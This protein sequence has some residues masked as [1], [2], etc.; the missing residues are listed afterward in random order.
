MKIGYILLQFPV[1]SETFIINELAELTNEGHE[2][3]V[4]SLLHPKKQFV[5]TEVTEYGLLERTYYLPGYIGLSLNLLR[6]QAWPLLFSDAIEVKPAKSKLLGSLFSAAAIDHLS[7]VIPHFNLDVL[8]TH[9]YGLT[10]FVAMQVSQRIGIPFTSTFHAFDIFTKPNAE[11]MRRHMEAAA[12]VITISGYNKDYL[13]KLTGIGA[14][15]TQ[16]IR[17][18]PILD[19]FKN[20]QTE[21]ES[22]SGLIILTVARLVEKKGVKYGILAMA[23][24][25]KEYPHL[26]Y[27]IIGDGPQRDELLALVKS[28]QLENN[29]KFLGQATDMT[30]LA[31]LRS[32][33]MVLLPC[34]QTENGDQDGIPVTLMEAM[35][36]KTP[37][38]STNVSGIPELIEDGKQGLLVEPENTL[39]LANAIKA[40]LNDAELRTR[41]GKAGSNKI[42]KEFNIRIE[43]HKLIE[44]WTA[45]VNSSNFTDTC[46]LQ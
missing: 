45:M 30:L 9:F 5:H 36:S 14:N 38:I 27:R 28:L 3:Y 18:C 34:V 37:V 21:G 39:Q 35:C 22:R 33:T 17:A 31:E 11:V 2:I 20:V 43:V 7:R 32:A 42:E 12:K 6:R 29:V 4:F 13:Q 8:H 10:T 16:V 24:L 19:K 25:V 26:C 15:K 44:I 1:V 46:S 40:L 41:L 23:E